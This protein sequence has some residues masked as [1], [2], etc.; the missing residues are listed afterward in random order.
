MQL[1]ELAGEVISHQAEVVNDPSK[2]EGVFARVADC[3]RM[4]R[5]Y[6]PTTSLERSIE[7]VYEYRPRRQITL[8]RSNN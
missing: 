4:F 7:I 8:T 2:P 3:S 5:Y 6:R 1:A